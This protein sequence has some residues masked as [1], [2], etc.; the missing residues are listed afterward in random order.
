MYMCTDA[1]N[2]DSE[3]ENYKSFSHAIK[4]KY[5]IKTA[6]IQK[7]KLLQ[8]LEWKALTLGSLRYYDC[9]GQENVA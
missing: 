2:S 4:K 7:G 9:D 8:I 1:H 6:G 3:W 5:I